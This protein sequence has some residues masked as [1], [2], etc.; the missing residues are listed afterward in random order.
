[1]GVPFISS[2]ARKRDHV[3]AIDLG[4]RTTKAVFVQRRG[5]QLTLA[6]YTV[7][8]SPVFEKALSAEVLAEHLK[9][10]VR[11]LGNRTRQLTLAL[12]VNET[13]FRQ[14]EA[15]MMPIPDLRLMFKFNSKT[16]LQQEL[17][18]HVFDCQFVLSN[19][20]KA[21][22]PKISANAK[23]KVMVGG[24]RKHAMDEVLNASKIANLVTDHVVPAVIGPVNAFELA[25]PE[26]FQKEVVALVEIGYKNSTITILDCSEIMLSR[27]VAIGGDR[28]TQGLAESLGISYPEAENIKLGMPGEVATNLEPLIHPLGRELR[29]SIDYFE[30]HHDKAV[31]KVY[32]SGG[33]ARSEVIFQTLQAELVVPCEMWSPAKTMQLTLPP[34][35]MGEIEQTAPTLTVAIGAAAAS[36]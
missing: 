14:V 5:D 2:H 35:R 11:V 18:D 34:E 1:M 6:N 8:D 19:A 9:E 17:P 16:Y 33:S 24:A 4:A 26:T 25:E 13:L 10:I 29:A 22:A 27:V 30:N 32:L 23:Q 36:F 20:V 12:G 21:E 3:L 15:P 7:I 28:L 31:S